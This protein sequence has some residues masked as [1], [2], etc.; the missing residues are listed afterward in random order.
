MPFER[1]KGFMALICELERN[2]LGLKA[3]EGS[4]NLRE[5]R[6]EP[7]I[8]SLMAK[9][10]SDSFHIDG[11]QKLFNDFNLRLVHLYPSL[12]HQVS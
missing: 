12:G 6:D 2:I 7:W 3:R 11:R 8:E 9:E 10:A 4:S 5:V 1:V